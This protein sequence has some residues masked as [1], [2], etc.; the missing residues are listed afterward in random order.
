MGIIISN[1]IRQQIIDHARME[2]PIE[3][4][5]YLAGNDN[6]VHEIYPMTNSDESPVHFSFIPEEQFHVYKE[7]RNRGLEIIG[8]YHSHPKTSAQISKEDI[9]LAYDSY[10]SYIIVSL[11]DDC[12]DI[13]SFR[14][15]DG[16]VEEEKVVLPDFKFYEIPGTLPDDIKSLDASIEKYKS[17][18]IHPVQFRA[19]RV[20]F[21]VYEQREENSFDHSWRQVR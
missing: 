17:G 14:V 13:K 11:A 7:V 20:L 6:V 4:C 3:A 19:A 5:G 15:K 16:V 21:G 1:N 12:E 18:N 10:V 9:R 2:A 8:V